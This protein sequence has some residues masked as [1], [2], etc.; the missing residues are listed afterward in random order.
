MNTFKSEACDVR[1][2]RAQKTKGYL[3]ESLIVYMTSLVNMAFANVISSFSLLPC[4]KLQ[5]PKR[6]NCLCNI[7]HKQARHAEKKL[8]T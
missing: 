7:S 6:S 3:M 1:R 2:I 8:L 4:I 5:V